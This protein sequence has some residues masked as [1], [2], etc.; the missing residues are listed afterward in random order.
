MS[1]G[2]REIRLFCRCG[3]MFVANGRVDAAA[4][5]RNG[6]Q[7]EHRSHGLATRE[8]AQRARAVQA[9]LEREKAG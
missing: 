9:R 8:Q 1:K 2:S 7:R 6:W 5:D 3:A 4:K